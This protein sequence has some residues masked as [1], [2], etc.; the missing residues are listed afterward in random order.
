MENTNAE[1]EGQ[2][3]VQ[4]KYIRR[5]YTKPAF[6]FEQVFVTSALTCSKTATQP[7][8]GLGGVSSAS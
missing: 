2:Q 5:P 8:C 6:R 3:M 4:E 7:S 1:A